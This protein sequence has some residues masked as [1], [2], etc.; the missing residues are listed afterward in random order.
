MSDSELM[1]REQALLISDDFPE[2]VFC[3]ENGKPL[4][5]GQIILNDS[6]G[7]FIDQY[8][9]TIEAVEMYPFRFPYVYET[10][11]R[12]PINVDW[13][14]FSDGH[15]CIKTIPEEYLL[16]KSGINLKWFIESQLIPYFFNQ[17][18]REIHGYYLNER[19]HGGQGV[20]EF[21]EELYAAII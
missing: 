17:K 5:K 6:D 7:K 12:L 10:G 15:C 9:V 11:G 4:L 1:F 2:L 19:P 8:E 18:H 20:I 21:F 14:L 13:H 16:C 3:E